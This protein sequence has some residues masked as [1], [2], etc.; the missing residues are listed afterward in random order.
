[1][2]IQ[3]ISISKKKTEFTKNA[4]LKNDCHQGKYSDNQVNR[5]NEPRTGELVLSNVL[6]FFKTIVFRVENSSESKKSEWF[7]QLKLS[8]NVINLLLFNNSWDSFGF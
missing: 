7:A 2:V 6:N 8:T 3:V 5:Q 1:M 4:I